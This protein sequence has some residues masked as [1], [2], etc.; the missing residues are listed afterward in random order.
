M[1]KK[2]NKK[3]NK[4]KNKM[5]TYK[6]TYFNLIIKKNGGTLGTLTLYPLRF[7]GKLL[8]WEVNPYSYGS[9]GTFNVNCIIQNSSTKNLNGINN[10]LNVASTT[11]IVE[12]DCMVKN[13]NT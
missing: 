8:E 5:E 11:F 9:Y 12:P 4:K 3:I 13:A 1:N 10:G 7:I 2:M 6:N